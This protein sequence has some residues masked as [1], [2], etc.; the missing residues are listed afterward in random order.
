MIRS[1]A[2]SVLLNNMAGIREV[3]SV[4]DERIP[5]IQGMHDNP[6]GSLHRV[7]GKLLTEVSVT[8]TVWS[9]KQLKFRDGNVIVT[10]TGPILEAT[11]DFIG[12]WGAVPYPN[13]EEDPMSAPEEPSTPIQVFAPFQEDIQTDEAA[14]GIVNPAP[15]ARPAIFHNHLWDYNVGID[16]TSVALNI[17]ESV[18]TA[19]FTVGVWPLAGFASLKFSWSNATW[20]SISNVTYVGNYSVT[21]GG[22]KGYGFFADGSFDSNEVFQVSVSNPPEGVSNVTVNVEAVA[23]SG[24]SIVTPT[25]SSVATTLS[26]SVSNIIPVY[27]GT[28]KYTIYTIFTNQNPPGPLNPSGLTGDY[29][30]TNVATCQVGPPRLWDSNFLPLNNG[31]SS[32]WLLDVTNKTLVDTAGLFPA[33]I[34]SSIV[35][36]IA[37]IPTMAQKYMGQRIVGPPAWNQNVDVYLTIEEP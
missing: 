18:T 33:N 15:D 2:E 36:T 31:E 20:L 11:R 29:T 5:D 17:Q 10:K 25:K 1:N 28:I 6:A 37:G 35:Y 26:V 22:T 19:N 7:P 3:E 13:I 9:I 27:T 30:Q 14:A 4:I 34:Y 12:G 23:V 16:P 32:R 21:N 24:N 8:S